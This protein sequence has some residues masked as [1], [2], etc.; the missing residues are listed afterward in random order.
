MRALLE[1]VLFGNLEEIEVLEFLAQREPQQLGE[2]AGAEHAKA[3]LEITRVLR[4]TA[5]ECN[6]LA[7]ELEKTITRVRG[8]WE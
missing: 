6:R 4:R 5:Q 3:V 2:V 1:L 7:D 8:W